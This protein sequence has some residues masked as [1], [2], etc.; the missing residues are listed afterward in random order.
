M[1]RHATWPVARIVVWVVVLGLVLLGTAGQGGDPRS[2]G[3]AVS[4]RPADSAGDSGADATLP[5]GSGATGE[6]ALTGIPAAD[7]VGSRT[8]P[9]LS[10]LDQERL[11]GELLASLPVPLGPQD[12][13]ALEE[14]YLR[15]LRDCPAASR[16]PEAAFRLASLYFENSEPPRVE[17]CL[18]ALKL[19]E[20]RYP[21]SAFARR[22]VP[23]L[24]QLAQQAEDWPFLA[25]YL[26]RLVHREDC[27]Q[28]DRI[29]YMVHLAE[30]LERL[31]RPDEGRPWL[32][33]VMR[34][35]AGTPMA[36][37]ARTILEQEAAGLPPDGGEDSLASPAEPLPASGADPVSGLSG[38]PAS[39][40]P[41][42]P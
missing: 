11:C 24:L 3:G 10:H 12:M 14:R 31:G 13:T 40:S 29:S 42:A 2:P 33:R 4:G 1:E 37:L 36:D 8:P 25:D 5:A 15:V 20:D 39:A 18:Q 19:L 32:E 23:R 17:P 35:A 41:L 28:A 9:L 38:A 30:V 16:A 6:A 26:D 21:T 22:A 7:P 27:L 34:E